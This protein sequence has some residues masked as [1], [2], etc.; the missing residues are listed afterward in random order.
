MTVLGALYLFSQ[1][2][3]S[4]LVTVILGK[5]LGKPCCSKTIVDDAEI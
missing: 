3:G 2:T 1:L 4:E 5:I